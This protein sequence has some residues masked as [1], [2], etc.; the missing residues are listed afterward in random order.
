MEYLYALETK[1]R[2]KAELELK[3]HK[4][5]IFQTTEILKVYKTEYKF[6]TKAELIALWNW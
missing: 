2:K 1:R 4:W 3:K 6:K 5:E